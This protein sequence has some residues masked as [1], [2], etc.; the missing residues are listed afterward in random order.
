[1]IQYLDE[2]SSVNI[3]DVSH[4]SYH[5]M[6]LDREDSVRRHLENLDTMKKLQVDIE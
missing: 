6:N 1:M 3:D 2:N 5:Y 4:Q